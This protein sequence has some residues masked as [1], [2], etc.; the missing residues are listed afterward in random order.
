[1]KT[2]HKTNKKNFYFHFSMLERKTLKIKQIE[3]KNDENYT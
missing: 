3:N 2:N 1:M